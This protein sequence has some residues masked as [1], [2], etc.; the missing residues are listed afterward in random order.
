MIKLLIIGFLATVVGFLSPTCLTGQT[1]S[2]SRTQTVSFIYDGAG[3]RTARTVPNPQA[4][5]AEENVASKENAANKETA[6]EVVFPQQAKLFP[7]PTDGI[8]I[9]EL[10]EIAVGASTEV[11]ISDLSGKMLFSSQ[12]LTERNSFDLNAQP[13]GI[14]LLKVRIND[15]ICIWKIIKK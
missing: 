15:E 3:N 5:L 10:P 6:V 2:R 8:V 7:N 13:S 12:T 14:Y 9:L 4:A 1:V 11:S